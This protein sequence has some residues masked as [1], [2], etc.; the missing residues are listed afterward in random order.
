MLNDLKTPKCELLDTIKIEV[1][2]AQKYLE[3]DITLS[4]NNVIDQYCKN[5]LSYLDRKDILNKWLGSD[6]LFRIN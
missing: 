3:D 4:A 2:I 5:K 1:E 6:S